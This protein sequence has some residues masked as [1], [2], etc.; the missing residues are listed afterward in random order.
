M[1]AINAIIV[2]TVCLVAFYILLHFNAAPLLTT[3]L[4]FSIP[5]TI[6]IM[7]LSVLLDDSKPYPELDNDEWG[8]KDKNNDELGIF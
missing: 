8:Y 4:Y 2:A 3:L 6:V 7:V 5:V 1:K